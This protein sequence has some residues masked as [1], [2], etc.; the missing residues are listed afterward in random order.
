MAQ[1]A[2][3]D[4]YVDLEADADLAQLAGFVVE[5]PV[6]RAGLVHS[7]AATTTFGPHRRSDVA[8]LFRRLAAARIGYRRE[9]VDVL[10]DQVIRSFDRMH[11]EGGTCLDLALVACAQLIAVDMRPHLVLDYGRTG[12][13]NRRESNH[14][15]VL[16]DLVT[17][18]TA[19]ERRRP[20]G[21]AATD[22]PVATWQQPTPLDNGWVLFDPTEACLAATRQFGHAEKAAW[23]RLGGGTGRTLLIDVAAAR[24][25]PTVEHRAVP[26]PEAPGLLSRHCP[27]APATVEFDSRRRD[28]DRLRARRGT[29]VLVGPRGAGKSVLALQAAESATRGAGWFLNGSGR[30]AL[31]SALATAEG[32][33]RNLP[34][35]V[36]AADVDGFARAA[37]SRL[38]AI[39]GPWTVVVDN[40]DGPVVP[41]L[42]YLPR[43]DARRGQ[44]LI[45]TSTD[46]DG[47]WRDTA[48]SGLDA[49]VQTVDDLDPA[50]V[51]AVLDGLLDEGVL[52]S[53]ALL[54]PLVVRSMRGLARTGHPRWARAVA[55]DPNPV[56]RY[57]QILRNELLDPD[58]ERL[59]RL[60]ALLPPDDM[61]TTVFAFVD[62]NAGPQLVRLRE[63]GLLGGGHGRWSLHRLLGQAVR[64]DAD[65]AAASAPMAAKLLAH[66]EGAE[67][68][69]RAY[70]AAVLDHLRALLVAGHVEGRAAGAALATVA[71]IV[72]QRGTALDASQIGAEAL[73]L[74]GPDNDPDLRA[75]CLLA[76]ARYVNQHPQNAAK[77]SG[78]GLDEELHLALSWAAAAH[79]LARD[80][81][82]TA[83]ALA[84]RGLLTKK[85]AG[86]HSGPRRLVVLREAEAMILQARDDRR[87][88]AGAMPAAE[89]SAEEL[90]LELAK[91]EFNVG[92]LSV[93]LAKTDPATAGAMLQQAGAA[94]RSV[95]DLR[96]E[97][98]GASAHR[99]IA[100][101]V[102]GEALVAYYRAVLVDATLA[103]ATASLREA[104]TKARQA[105][106][107]REMLEPGLDEADTTKSVRLLGKIALARLTVAADPVEDPTGK[108]VTETS[109]EVAALMER[110]AVTEPQKELQ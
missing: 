39:E 31:V 19:R 6:L 85:L 29:T 83:K 55:L 74:L 40:A 106:A 63:L 17:S 108:L 109:D 73:E 66:P 33:E 58:E 12:A 16:V 24:S 13:G 101:C 20:A 48:A 30:Q 110:L 9:A 11:R 88:L 93:Q 78:H 15:L 32:H 71:S 50:E 7:D 18:R 28:L 105:L 49:S 86:L 2:W 57:W 81:M 75:H 68:F 44:H 64:G 65:H 26:P 25:D 35:T 103:T 104:T 47:G 1:V 8:E 96:R 45:I 54:L 59:A 27:P 94:Y 102:A 97:V 79:D 84:M 99:H 41:L 69:A 53:P 80:P 38:H 100:S 10:G 60:A 92:G 77:R 61:P 62:A 56:A 4:G 36:V 89:A 5:A 46:A 52:R 90:K 72:D 107:D 95:G 3:D 67:F 87:R 82:L 21:A 34:N 76:R 70:D 51:H 42:D 43:A 98:F 14:A 91:A 23:D 22:G 37:L